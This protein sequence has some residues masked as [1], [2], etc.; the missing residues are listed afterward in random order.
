M[1]D[2][3]LQ[4]FVPKKIETKSGNKEYSLQINKSNQKVL[5]ANTK[6][7]HKSF[8]RRKYITVPHNSLCIR[9]RW[10]AGRN[11]SSDV[12][13]GS[14]YKYFIMP[15]K[16]PL[17]KITLNAL[18]LLQAEMTKHTKRASSII[19][20]NS[21]PALITLV[22]DFFKRFGIHDDDWSWNITF[23]YK[24]KNFENLSDTQK[25]ER[26]SLRYWLKNTNINLGSK[27]NKFMLYGGNKKYK[28]FDK[29]TVRSGTLVICH[30][31]IILYQ[32]IL[33]ILSRIN[34]LFIDAE[35]TTYFLQ[36][37]IAGDGSLKFT[38]TGSIDN[39][40]I[41]AI[42]LKEKKVIVSYLKNIGIES[43]FSKGDKNAVRIFN[44]K[45]FFKIYEYGLFDL[46]KERKHRFLKGL[47]RF[48]YS[49]S[50]IS[51][52]ENLFR[53]QKNINGVDMN[54]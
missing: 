16:L 31:N 7:K 27:R 51:I 21:N 37:L 18:G 41:G 32:F 38:P 9:Y 28:N 3:E 19:F 4:E 17:D 46:H 54:G 22:M 2:I 10:P 52:K 50:D 5:V 48:K 35:K 34:E 45:N 6:D 29:E 42:E 11:Q 1:K 13:K 33:E 39:V 26:K 20:T 30:S 40:N 43:S 36:G 15:E 25:R 44:R 47:I 8:Y 14:R 23:N 12:N 24:L 53:I 49:S